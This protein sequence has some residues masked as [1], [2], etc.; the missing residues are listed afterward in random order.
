[1]NTATIPL[2]LFCFHIKLVI[3]FFFVHLK[4][5]YVDNDRENSSE[6]KNIQR[7]PGLLLLRFSIDDDSNKNKKYYPCDIDY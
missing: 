7:K 2:S 4:A 3:A 5:N 6:S 1:M